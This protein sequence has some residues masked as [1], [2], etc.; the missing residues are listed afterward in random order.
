MFVRTQHSYNE[1]ALSGLYHS[2]KEGRIILNELATMPRQQETLLESLE[3]RLAGHKEITRRGIVTFFKTLETFGV[4]EF[5][6]GRRGH[7]SRFKWEVDSVNVSRLDVEFPN[8]NGEPVQAEQY[9]HEQGKHEQGSNV[10]THKFQLR[11][12]MVV[13]INLP[14]NITVSEAA[15]FCKFIESLPFGE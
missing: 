11:P 3:K 9:K 14:S 12:E 1:K 7:S 4:G 5:I 8:G 2:S 6:P 13:S 15:R 10:I